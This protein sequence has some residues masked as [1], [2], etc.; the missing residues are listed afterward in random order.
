MVTELRPSLTGTNHTLPFEKLSP[1]DF[2]RLCYALVIREG[3]ERVEY[4]GEA[5]NEQGRDVVAWRDGRR[6]VFQCKR[7]ARFTAK[8][9]QLEIAKLRTLPV[10][11]QPQELVFV[12]PQPVSVKTRQ[13]LRAAW[14]DEATC[15]FWSGAELDERVKRHEDLLREYFQLPA[16]VALKAPGRKPSRAERFAQQRATLEKQLLLAKKRYYQA[17]KDGEGA[18]EAKAEIRRLKQALRSLGELQPR[19]ELAGGRYWLIAPLGRGGFAQVWLALDTTLER[20]VA[21]KIL[22]H[23]AESGSLARERFLCGARAMAQLDHPGIVKVFEVMVEDEDRLFFVMEYLEGG[24]LR[25]A[26]KEKRLSQEQAFEAVFEV[27]KALSY[28]HGKGFVHRDV[29]PANIVLDLAG[30]AKLTDFDLVRGLE[31]SGWTRTSAQVGSVL[32]AAP[33]ALTEGREAGIPADVY[34]L[35]MTVCFVLHGNDPPGSAIHDLASFRDNLPCADTVKGV[36]ARATRAQPGD[37]FESVAALLAGLNALIE[38]GPILVNPREPSLLTSQRPQWASGAGEDNF[39]HWADFEVSGVVHRMRWI[40]PGKFW[41]GSP[42]GEAGR[43]DSEGP[44]HEVTLTRG[45]WLGEVPCTQELWQAVTG[46]NPSRFQGASR[47]VEQVSWKDC[48]DFLRRL[49][50]KCPGLGARLPTEAEW[51]HACRAGTGTATWAGDLFLDGRKAPEL[52]SVAWYFGNSSLQTQP[53]KTKTPNPWGLYDI[54]GNVWE[55]CEDWYGR[56]DS[57]AVTDPAGPS[58]GSRRVFR[59]GSWSNLALN[60]RAAARLGY[61]PD[62]RNDGLG[63]RL[64]RGQGPAPSGPGG[65][66]PRE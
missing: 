31:S 5:G 22:S 33:E 3:Y 14:E 40:P 51:E 36:L 16:E 45:F 48:Q 30:K 35:A 13:A 18:T 8:L 17:R 55:W 58:W 6:V 9:G 49:E 42:E 43:F 65:R 34:S 46:S 66:S 57:T 53:V 63:F 61:S 2:E 38:P 21:I 37:R 4:L 64:A 7:V 12:V 56:Y 60:V 23:D 59:G 62:Y 25:R 11:E 47:P 1:K 41:M 52:E 26:L 10:G 50:V 44:R 20:E 15:G 32:Y 27:G 24:D 39:G 19:D 28:A 29:K 54:L